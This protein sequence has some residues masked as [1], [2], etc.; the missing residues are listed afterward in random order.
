[1]PGSLGSYRRQL[2]SQLPM[3]ETKEKEETEKKPLFGIRKQVRDERESVNMD[4]SAV[5]CSRVSASPPSQVGSRQPAL[6]DLP[7]LMSIK[8]PT[9]TGCYLI[10]NNGPQ[11]EALHV[12]AGGPSYLSTYLDAHVGL[13]VHSMKPLLGL[14]PGR[15]CPHAPGHLPR[16]ASRLCRSSLEWPPICC[17]WGSTYVLA[18]PWSCCRALPCQLCTWP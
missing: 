2:C 10:T 16:S 6:D 3:V 4:S 11:L 14:P 13:V 17:G 9:D 18:G 7:H 1:M 12:R 15:A 8:R 5:Y